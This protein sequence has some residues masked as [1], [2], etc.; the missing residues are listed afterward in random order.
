[1]SA[2]SILVV[3]SIALVLGFIVGWLARDPWP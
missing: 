3:V 1:M 2:F